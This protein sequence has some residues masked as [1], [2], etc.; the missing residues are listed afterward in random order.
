MIDLNVGRWLRQWLA[1]NAAVSALVSSQI[2]PVHVPYAVGTAGKP[3]LCYRRQR[4]ELPASTQGLQGNARMTVRI[5]A[6]ANDYDAAADAISAVV[7]ALG[8]AKGGIISYNFRVASLIVQDAGDEF[9]QPQD[10]GETFL[11]APYCDVLVSFLDNPGWAPGL[12][13]L[14][15]T[16]TDATGTGLAAHT[17]EI[18]AGWTE[19]DAGSGTGVIQG[20][21]CQLVPDN[22][23]FLSSWTV[24]T[25]HKDGSFSLIVNF[26]SAGIPSGHEMFLG[27]VMRWQDGNNYLYAVATHSNDL[28]IWEVIG[29]TPHRRASTPLD[30]GNAAKYDT[31][32][33]ITLALSGAGIVADCNGVQAGYG[34][35]S[36]NPTGT[37]HG[38]FASGSGGD[39]G[40]VD[41]FQFTNP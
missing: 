21:R 9:Q 6:V 39:Y 12:Y 11:Y 38:I 23:S 27:V 17:A 20:N 37:T 10:A 24:P 41:N 25:T 29:G 28:S 4:T 16:F 15:D 35:L 40:L 14:Q 36:V 30:G 7:D 13:L 26:P 33:L 19:R 3:S 32:Y 34:S 2:Y 5:N 22:S 18:A 8:K 31:D 1:A